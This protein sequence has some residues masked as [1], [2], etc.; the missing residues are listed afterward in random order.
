KMFLHLLPLYHFS[1]LLLLRFFFFLHS[2][3]SQKCLNAVSCFFPSACIQKIAD[4]TMVFIRVVKSQIKSVRVLLTHLD[5]SHSC[6]SARYCN[7]YRFAFALTSLI[8]KYAPWYFFQTS[9]MVLFS[10]MAPPPAN[11]VCVVPKS[12]PIS[13]KIPSSSDTYRIVIS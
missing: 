1:F 9:C 13:R 3:I 12:M 5:S 6:F 10:R 2:P 4:F 7:L 8:I 11:T